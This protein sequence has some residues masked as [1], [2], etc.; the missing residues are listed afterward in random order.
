MTDV[1]AKPPPYASARQLISE[2]LQLLLPPTRETIDEYAAKHRLLPRKNGNGFDLY[3][4]DEAPYLALP[5]RTVRSHTYLTTAI[6]GPAQCG[7]T[8]VA[9][10]ELL[11]AVEKQPGSLLWY[12]QTDESLEAYVKA[13]INPMVLAHE[14]MRSR[15]GPKPEDDAQ[16]FKNFGSMRAEF[17]SYTYSNLINKNAPLI[18]ADEW[19][20]YDLSHGDPKGLLDRRRQYYG[21]LSHLLAISHPDLAGG[22]DPVKHWTKGIMRLFADST[23]FIW[24]WPCPHCGA[25]S[26]PVPIAR[27]VMTLEWPED[28]TL[29][30]I[31]RE[32]HLL[33][34]VSGCVIT[35]RER[36]GMNIAAF[37]S[38][39]GGWVGQGQEISEDGEVSGELIKA[40]TAGFWIVGAM[41]NFLLK[42]IG[43]LARDW[44]KAQR[45]FEV[46]GDDV[47]LKEV[48]VKQVGVPHSRL[49]AIGNVEAETLAER[50]LIEEQPLGVVPEGVR[51]LFAWFD[52]QP[53]YFDLMVRGFGID[54]E[55]W[56]ID[57][58]HIPAET[59]TDRKA[60]DDLLEELIGKRYPLATDQTRGM[61]I[62]GIGYD[63][64]GAPGTTD[65]AYSVW[66]RL[67]EKRLLKNYGRLDGRDLHSVAPTKGASSLNAPML[68]LVY[69]SSQRKD[70]KVVRA[71]IEPLTIFNPN[72]FKDDL[73]GQLQIAQPGPGYVH[74]PKVLRSKEPP[75]VLFEQLVAE[76][77]KTSGQWEKPAG[78]RN[79]MTDLMVG[80]HAIAKLHGLHR[81]KWD[82]PQFAWALPWDKNSMVGPMTAPPSAGGGSSPP[83]NGGGGPPADNG[84]K[85]RTIFDLVGD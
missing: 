61:A 47:A 11:H 32:A 20:A 64:A 15:L 10:N 3:S 5:M 58:R 30:E 68:T 13:R 31:E 45:E 22:L 14:G 55:S 74:L 66:R 65:Q 62:R 51:V 44:A 50:S 23:R 19:D 80:T 1:L 77:R 2:A 81:V 76:N 82:A 57:K 54:A 53:T 17:L 78:V 72:V 70:R 41:S 43:G 12:M 49:S 56:V 29:D 67:R 37:N 27:R 7:K 69:P 4:H 73:A 9:E 16:H 34:P 83:G 33:C 48:V 25:W 42:G 28:G 18:V 40:D 46:S 52:V 26:S 84:G 85:P 79:E 36:R 24:Y 35:D 75:H 60:W 63:S 6:V 71:G 8:V 21:R 59:A 38:P 39:F